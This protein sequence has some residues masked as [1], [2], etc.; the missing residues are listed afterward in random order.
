MTSPP[1]QGFSMAGLRKGSILFMNSLEYIRVNKPRYF[2]FENVKGLLSHDKKNKDAIYGRTFQ[3]WINYLGGK[4]VNG[5]PTLFP[6]EGSVPY[7]IYFK[8]INAK[9]YGVPQ[10]RERIFIVGIRD[11]VDNHFHWPKSFPLKKRLKDVLETEV[12]E[13]YFLSDVALEGLFNHSERHKEAGNGFGANISDENEI[14]HTIKSP[15]YKDGSDQLIELN[16]VGSL[17]PDNSD[18]GRIVDPSG[19]S[20]TIKA[21]GGG[22]GAKTGLY[23]I[24]E[25]EAGRIIGRNPQN[26]KSRAIGLP[27]EQ[28]I[29]VN[30]DC[31]IVNTLTTVQK[32]NVFILGYTRD[33]K[34]KVTSRHKKDIANTIHTSIG[35]GG[36][37]DQFA[38]SSKR[39]RR[40]TPRE[41]F[42]LM[43]FPEDFKITV[44]DTQA[45]RQAGNSIV[46]EP[47][48]LI[49]AKLLKIPYH[50]KP[51]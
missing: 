40:L 46:V 10:N 26:P 25:I 32:D 17:Y 12:N 19:I 27:T 14:S 44:S 29:E 1:C 6:A 4:S 11:D 18:A 24:D 3:E 47:L 49:I 8:V 41:C 42:R 33:E 28:T 50:G 51:N 7:H 9:K 39:I 45:Y 5:V 30:E 43:D 16:Q 35:G 34:G 22:M 20:C 15:Y 2:D 36:N 21:E 37:T 48:A 13:K 23:A 31:T 38:I